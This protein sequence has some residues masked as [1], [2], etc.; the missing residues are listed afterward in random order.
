MLDM[1]NL[2][3]QLNFKCPIQTYKVKKEGLAGQCCSG[4]LC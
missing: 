3:F 1:L 2:H 4:E